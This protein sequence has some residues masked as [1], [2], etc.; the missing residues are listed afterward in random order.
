MLTNKGRVFGYGKSNVLGI[1]VSTQD[2]KENVEVTKLTNSN[3]YDIEQI[4]SGSGWFIAI[5]SDGTVWGTGSNQY[6]ILGRWIGVDRDTPN[7]RY[8]TAFEW[9]EC[10]ELEI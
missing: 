1:G 4:V 5:K 3:F 8:K 9:V 6:G 7:S 10:P 2:N